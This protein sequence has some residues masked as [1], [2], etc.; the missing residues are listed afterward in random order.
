MPWFDPP[1]TVP[2]T[3]TWIFPGAPGA[4]HK[5]GQWPHPNT[6]R[7]D[8]RF[9]LRTTIDLASTAY[10]RLFSWEMKDTTDAP[11]FP[12]W[13]EWGEWDLL[14]SV[15][16]TIA[17][18]SDTNSFGWVASIEIKEFTTLPTAGVPG[19][20]LTLKAEHAASGHFRTHYFEFEEATNQWFYDRDIGSD[21]LGWAATD[22]SANFPYATPLALDYAMSDCFL[23][24]RIAPPPGGFADFNGIDAYIGF[25]DY[26]NVTNQRIELTFDVW[27]RDT[28]ELALLGP[29]FSSSKYV[30]FRPGGI[31]WRSS[32]VVWSPDLPFGEW[33]SI[34]AEFNWQDP[35][36]NWKV[37]SNDVLLG[38]NPIHGA[39]G[40]R[41]N[42][43]GRRGSIIQGNFQ[44]KNLVL[45]DTDP[46]APRIMWDCLLQVDACDTGE[47][48][49]KGT[50][51]NMDLASCP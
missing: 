49:L 43:L 22:E 13:I 39:S 12:D 31:A 48:T 8:A 36:T 40:L 14:V 16:G 2:E 19:I 21:F 46:A 35:G 9:R 20:L 33:L 10:R 11:A 1:A 30:M 5:V 28:G 38:T 17:A 25:N 51:F 7:V 29:L 15:E 6:N 41:F 24:P 45:K 26:T 34:R 50:T 4:K 47:K 32:A 23:F 3:L 44:L 27:L 18:T 42:Q 37:Y